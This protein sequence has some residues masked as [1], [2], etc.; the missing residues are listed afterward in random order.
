MV[1]FAVLAA[2]LFADVVGF[3]RMMAADETSV[4]ASLKNH[5]GEL[6]G[7]GIAENDGRIVKTMGDGVLADF[8]KSTFEHGQSATASKIHSKPQVTIALSLRSA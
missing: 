8:G 1:S 2:V 7:P 6:I 5:L 4:L 3:S